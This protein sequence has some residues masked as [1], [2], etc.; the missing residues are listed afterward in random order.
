MGQWPLIAYGDVSDWASLIN[1]DVKGCAMPPADAGPL[2]N[3]DRA[4]LLNWIACGA[5]NN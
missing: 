5:P 3:A 1:F 2:T 4:T